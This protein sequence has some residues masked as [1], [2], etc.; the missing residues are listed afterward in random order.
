[1]TSGALVLRRSICR[2]RL[3]ASGVLLVLRWTTI[4]KV[5]G[6]NA[7]K[8]WLYLAAK[9]LGVGPARHCLLLWLQWV[10]T[11]V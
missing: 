10:V 2:G 1:M 4:K 6:V 7:M 11:P 8:C 9:A 3:R 5:L